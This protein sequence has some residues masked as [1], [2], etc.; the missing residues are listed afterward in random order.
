MP[1]EVMGIT[2]CRLPHPTKP[3]TRCGAKFVGPQHLMIGGS[4]N[5]QGSRMAGLLEKLVKHLVELHPRVMGDVI[6]QGEQYK[7]L[8][9]M[10]NFTTTDREFQE[11]RNYYRWSVHQQTLNARLTDEKLRAAALEIAADVMVEDD[12]RSIAHSI[13]VELR[14]IRDALQEPVEP[15][16]P[17]APKLQTL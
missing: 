1:H 6:L 15:P 4:G 16:N 13:E 7:G 12:E 17:L 3:N 2:T 9:M 11:Q 8:L 10:M 5:G 14:T